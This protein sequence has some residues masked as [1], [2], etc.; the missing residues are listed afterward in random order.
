MRKTIIAIIMSLML[1]SAVSASSVSMTFSG[2]LTVPHESTA[3]IAGEK[4]EFP[5]NGYT[6]AGADG[7]IGVGYNFND[8]IGLGTS[9]G[10]T[11]NHLIGNDLPYEDL[12]SIQFAAD[13]TIS[14]SAGDYAIVTLPITLSLG[15]YLQALD[16][17][18]WNIGPMAA[19]TVGPRIKLNQTC[20][21]DLRA[22]AEILL[23]FGADISDVSTQLNIRCIS[24]GL[25]IDFPTDDFKGFV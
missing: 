20:Y 7:R 22:G 1:V 25:T 24:I 6:I 8:F 16:W 11:W 13:L 12:S 2:G 5:L 15:G 18:G 23:Q 3:I 10:L 19:I 17:S 4:N 14:P 9:F 21:L